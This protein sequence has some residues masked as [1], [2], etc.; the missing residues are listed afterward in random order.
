MELNEKNDILDNMIQK[1]YD[2]FASYIDL[3]RK[4]ED[5]ESKEMTPQ[6]NYQNMKANY[7]TREY[8]NKNIAKLPFY[9]LLCYVSGRK[10]SNDK[11]KNME[12]YL[13]L[14]EI[15]KFLA[16]FDNDDFNKV[17]KS[18]ELIK[19]WLDLDFYVSQKI[20]DQYINSVPTSLLR[21]LNNTSIKDYKKI[22]KEVN[23]VESMLDTFPDFLNYLNSLKLERN[24][25][26]I[27]D[28]LNSLKKFFLPFL[29]SYSKITEEERKNLLE[30]IWVSLENKIIAYERRKSLFYFPDKSWLPDYQKFMDYVI[31]A[32]EEFTFNQL[33]V[34]GIDKSLGDIN[35]K[36]SYRISCMDEL[37]EILS[38]KDIKVIYQNEILEKKKEI[39]YELGISLSIEDVDQILYDAFEFSPTS[40]IDILNKIAVSASIREIHDL[41]NLLFEQLDS[42]TDAELGISLLGEIRNH[43]NS[44]KGP[45]QIRKP[46]PGT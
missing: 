25:R 27:N 42:F 33:C 37:I 7:V 31:G 39:L 18:A 34:E 46:H 15:T 30:N 44:E 29:K 9:V 17:Q 40:L 3:K 4:K 36:I 8:D 10:I 14:D 32:Y 6:A 38:S 20:V 41:T 22:V 26:I 28:E 2:F 43:V 5:F 13:E 1:Y 12:K 35:K 16:G 19:E 45:Y 23:E 21:Q 11:T 24:S